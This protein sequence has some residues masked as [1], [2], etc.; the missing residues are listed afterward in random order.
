LAI[1]EDF[2]GGSPLKDL[3]GGASGLTFL[4]FNGHGFRHL[5]RSFDAESLYQ[6]FE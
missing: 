6:R 4:D 2:I 5:D 1:A 3:G